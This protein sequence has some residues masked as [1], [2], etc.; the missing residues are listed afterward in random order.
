MT[1]KELRKYSESNAVKLSINVGKIRPDDS[2]MHGPL[3]AATHFGHTNSS[4]KGRN[5]TEE[6]L[7]KLRAASVAGMGY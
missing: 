4:N 1:L 3:I 6:F 5:K 2:I 7:K